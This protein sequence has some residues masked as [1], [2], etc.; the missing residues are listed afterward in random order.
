MKKRFAVFIALTLVLFLVPT[1]YADDANLK[2]IFKG[3]V[4]HGY[5]YNASGE[6]F[7][8]TLFRE[9]LKV[10]LDF[11]HASFVVLNGTCVEDAYIQACLTDIVFSHYNYSLSFEERVVYAGKLI[12]DGRFAKANFDKKIEK[13]KMLVDDQSKVT[14]DFKNNGSIKVKN[15]SLA[16]CYPNS[17]EISTTDSTCKLKKNCILWEGDLQV[18]DKVTC[19]YWIKP[20]DAIFF[21]SSANFSYDSGVSFKNE[22]YLDKV[23]AFYTIVF[24]ENLTKSNLSLGEDLTLYINLTANVSVLIDNYKI[25]I[26]EGLEVTDFDSAYSMATLKHDV[27]LEQVTEKV[28]KLKGRLK[29]GERINIT[30]QLTSV[31]TGNQTITQ[32]IE[33]S[34]EAMKQTET[35][36]LSTVV[37]IGKPY[38]RFHRNVYSNDDNLKIFIVNPTDYTLFNIK[39]SLTT[40]LPISGTFETSA[41]K[42]LMHKEYNIPFNHRKDGNYSVVVLLNYETEYG[43]SFAF[44][45]MK[46]MAIGQEYVDALEA[47]RRAE[48]GGGGSDKV[49]RDGVVDKGKKG[50]I[51]SLKDPDGDDEADVTPLSLSPIS[52]GRKL[53]AIILPLFI[54]GAI[55]FISVILSSK[56]KEQNF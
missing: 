10:I 15:V 29:P 12:V 20:T 6:V 11:D 31:E 32:E 18:R 45:D 26:P 37:S 3:D 42:P 27:F 55:I 52:G 49:S 53:I 14:I 23:Q 56:Q 44:N 38:A 1:V 50:G 13:N 47:A 19:S 35:R 24:W 25:T 5:T 40:E 46:Y 39:L 48:E 54:I 34:Y 36:E 9:E 43:E 21:I 41:I 30:M 17:I 28:Y 7:D 2:R 16:D 51:P 33:S 8:V 4:F 22:K